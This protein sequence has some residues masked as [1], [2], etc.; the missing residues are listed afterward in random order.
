MV[1]SSGCAASMV[2]ECKQTRP[3]NS[4]WTK[5]SNGIHQGASQPSPSAKFGLDQIPRA[6]RE[7]SF[8]QRPHHL[9]PRGFIASRWALW[10]EAHDVGLRGHGQFPICTFLNHRR[11]C[12]PQRPH[13]VD[14]F[15]PNPPSIFRLDSREPGA[16]HAF[17]AFKGAFPRVPP[18]GL[19]GVVPEVL[20][21]LREGR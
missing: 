2:A 21:V 15:G 5:Y 19:I 11:K 9:I 12:G 6:F 3:S 1:D 14:Q 20:C 18:M 16:Q 4:V 8:P 10:P 17:G 7:V 13:A